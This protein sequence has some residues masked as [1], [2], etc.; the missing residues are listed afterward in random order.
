MGVQIAPLTLF[1]L[2]VCVHGVSYTALQ[3]TFLEKAEGKSQQYFADLGLIFAP[4]SLVLPPFLRLVSKGSSIN[5]V[6]LMQGGR[7]CRGVTEK[8]IYYLP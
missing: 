7:E 3:T 6:V 1:H 2:I 8:T 4:F 5:Y